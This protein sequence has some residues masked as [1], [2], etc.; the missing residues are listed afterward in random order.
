MKKEALDSAHP[1]NPQHAS[2]S[3]FVSTSLQPPDEIRGDLPRS[4][5]HRRVVDEPAALG[6]H[7]HRLERQGSQNGRRVLEGFWNPPHRRPR[8]AQERAVSGKAERQEEERMKE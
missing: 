6:L 7:L 8:N 4:P 5:L 2:A 3:A 1:T